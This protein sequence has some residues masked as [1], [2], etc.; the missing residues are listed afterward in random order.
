M[1]ATEFYLQD[2]LV[3]RD[4]NRAEAEDILN[5]EAQ[6]GFNHGKLV[7]PFPYNSSSMP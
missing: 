7:Q 1:T 2:V 3:R 4:V 6:G 5:I